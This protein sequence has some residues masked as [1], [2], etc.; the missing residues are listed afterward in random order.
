MVALGI[1]LFYIYIYID[2][3]FFMEI[4]Y[5][6]TFLFV[7]KKIFKARVFGLVENDILSYFNV[8]RQFLVLV[9]ML[10]NH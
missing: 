9:K 4:I 7:R 1:Y 5:F 10:M 8:A 2:I 3:S 6:K